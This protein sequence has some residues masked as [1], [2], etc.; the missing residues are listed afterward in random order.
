MSQNILE[1][2][3]SLPPLPKTI[4]EI[5][6]FR[7]KSE[8]DPFEL[9]KI[10]E[11]DALIISTLLKVSNS[12]MFGFR[13]KVETP[14]RA[15]NLLGINF[16]ISIAIGGTVQNLLKANLSAYGINSDDFMKIS[17]MSTTL[18]NLWLGKV[19]YDLKEELILPA[20][21]QEA[22]KFVIADILE[23]ENK[24]PE[25]KTL[26]HD[27]YSTAQAEK[28]I[29]GITTSQVTAQIFKHWKL[30]ENL[31]NS[32]EYV[33]DISNVPAEYKQKAQILDVIKTACE[34]TDP[35]SDDKIEKA[36]NK[37]KAYSLDEKHLLDAIEK[38][39]DRLLDEQ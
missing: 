34:V 18:A 3:E 13:S 2:I 4:T 1:K 6:E 14:S 26:L 27:G 23:L 20:L 19:S 35:L 28:E 12:A 33:D 16:T 5:E 36:V 8:K 24:T 21:L 22:G 17:N 38:L 15:I 29:I 9:L 39:Q 25:F 30:S 11:K 7:Q 37:A 31:I 32:I 10:I